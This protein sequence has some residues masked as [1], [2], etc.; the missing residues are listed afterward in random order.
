MMTLVRRRQRTPRNEK[1]REIQ[2]RNVQ[3]AAWEGG[4]TS[5]GAASERRAGLTATVAA[6]TSRGLGRAAEIVG[7]MTCV[8]GAVLPDEMSQQF[9]PS[10][11]L[12][13]AIV[14]PECIVAIMSQSG[15]HPAAD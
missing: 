14:E 9:F 12:C 8:A 6:L 13:I 15:G 11:R 7:A 1:E 3:S 2:I 5:G 10:G 4:K